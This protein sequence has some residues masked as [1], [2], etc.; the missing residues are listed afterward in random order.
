[1]YRSHQLVGTEYT[2]YARISAVELSTS[3]YVE[4]WN[5]NVSNDIYS[6]ISVDTSGIRQ[7]V[8]HTLHN[9]PPRFK[10]A[11]YA[12]NEMIKEH[13]YNKELF[14]CKVKMCPRLGITLRR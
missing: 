7:V 8:L 3:I 2:Q 6:R 5:R 10:T 12:G 11:V 14:T 13:I 4:V 9:I 1:M